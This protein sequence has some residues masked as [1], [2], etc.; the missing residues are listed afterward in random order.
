MF[1][2]TEDKYKN[3]LEEFKA[4]FNWNKGNPHVSLASLTPNEI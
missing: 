3:Q 1:S 4:K 2:K